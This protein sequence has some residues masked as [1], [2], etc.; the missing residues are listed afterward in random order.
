MGE[1]PAR[2]LLLPWPSPSPLR[3]SFPICKVGTRGQCE[4]RRPE[5]WQ[6][7]VAISSLPPT[8]LCPA[9]ALPGGFWVPCPPGWGRC[10]SLGW[11]GFRGAARRG[12]QPTLASAHRQLSRPSS[13]SWRPWPGCPSPRANPFHTSVGC[14]VSRG[15]GGGLS[16]LGTRVSV[17]RTGHVALG[18]ALI[19]PG[20]LCPCRCMNR[21]SENTPW[22]PVLR[23][24]V[25]HP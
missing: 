9:P 7:P 24:V 11:G 18:S 23:P 20:F 8:R 14:Q 2:R 17:P 16:G 22:A 25:P 19:L 4:Y 5:T 3:L 13:P 6:E 10:P 15:G 1:I 21:L 12:A